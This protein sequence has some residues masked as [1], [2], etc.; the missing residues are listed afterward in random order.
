M[1]GKM[2]I[3]PNYMYLNY[4]KGSERIECDPRFTS[5]HFHVDIYFLATVFNAP[6]LTQ[7]IT[8]VFSIFHLK[9]TNEVEN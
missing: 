8:K 2:S 6:I 3:T 1:S 9:I 7:R 5:H 4:L